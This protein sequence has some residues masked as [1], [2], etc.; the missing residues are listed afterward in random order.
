MNKAATADCPRTTW[1]QT[2]VHYLELIR[3]SH[4]IFALPFALL[5]TVWAFVVPIP[6][7]NAAI[8]SVALEL[9]VPAYVAVQGKVLA[10]VLLCMVAARSFAM[11]MNRYLDQKWDRENP[12]TANRH[13]PAGILSSVNVLWFSILCA[14]AFVAAC[15]L[16]WPNRLPLLLSI[17]VLVFLAGY[18]LAKRFT[19]LVHFWLGAALMLAPICAWIAIRGEIVQSHPSDLLP[20]ICLGCVV[21][22][23]VSGFD[24]IYAC[25]DT[26]YDRSA[27]LFSIPARIG[28]KNALR[29]AALCHAAMWCMAMLMSFCLPELSLGWVFR[30]VLLLIA[31]LLV[32]EHSV[33]SEKS[34]ARV[35]LAFFKL[36]SVISVL[37]LVFGALDALWR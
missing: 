18:S 16:F 21:L 27:G 9:S 13:I 23:W 28:V 1:G 36:N 6:L 34:L 12:R 32:I 14:V 17:P 2:V 29:L 5:A 15:G 4:T 22:L 30:G 33:V 20:A 31:V 37:F 7:T 8:R 24:I 3:F 19:I 25:Q 26:E 35:Q 10:G 11:A